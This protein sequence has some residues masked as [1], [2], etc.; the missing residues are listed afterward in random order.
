MFDLDG[1][2]IDTFYARVRLAARVAESSL[3]IDSWRIIGASARAAASPRA[4]PPNSGARSMLRGGN[5]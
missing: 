3:A 5:P 2:L 4:R 1:T